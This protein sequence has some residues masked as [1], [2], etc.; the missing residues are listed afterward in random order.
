M[1]NQNN[2][3]DTMLTLGNLFQQD[4]PSAYIL[5]V[6]PSPFSDNFHFKNKTKYRLF[7]NPAKV[8]D[9]QR[10]LVALRFCCVAGNKL[11]ILVHQ[12]PSKF[13]SSH[14]KKWLPNFVEPMVKTIDEGLV[15]D[16]PLI[17]SFPLEEIPEEK[18]AVNP[19]MHYRVLEKAAIPDIGVRYP[20][21]FTEENIV[22]PCMIKVKKYPAFKK[23][24]EQN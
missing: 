6:Y 18:H 4:V 3:S 10:F 11:P 15:D 13:L 12:L 19:D 9:A 14:W 5:P 1:D 23:M 24:W 21:Y 17:T 16:N 2:N 7:N 8:S 22:F 20:S